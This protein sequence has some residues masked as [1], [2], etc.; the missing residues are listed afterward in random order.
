MKHFAQI[1]RD[2]D[3]LISEFKL[4]VKAD[5]DNKLTLEDFQEFKWVLDSKPRI[6]AE[7]KNE[8]EQILRQLKYMRIQ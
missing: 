1:I 3:L 6:T 5:M 4:K 7:S 2:Q 8:H